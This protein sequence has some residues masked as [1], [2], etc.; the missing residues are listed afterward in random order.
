M[1]I[2]ENKVLQQ[3]TCLQ[4]QFFS[5]L[6][7]KP[8]CS[9]DLSFGLKIRSKDIAQYQKYIQPNPHT[10]LFWLCFDIDYPCVLETTFKEKVLPTPNFMISN[11]INNHCHLVYGIKEG[12]YLTDNAHINPIRY[13]HAISYSLREALLADSGYA[14]LIIKNPLHSSWDTVE[15]EQNLWS[16]PE[17]HDFLILPDKLPKKENILGLG[18]NC[19]LFHV[20]RKYA[21]KEVLTQKISGNKDSFF[22]AVLYFIEQHN[23]TFPF[24]LLYNEC[25]AIAKS[26]SSWTWKHFGNKST[27]QWAIYVKDTHTAEMQAYRGKQN[28][29]LQQSIKGKKGGLNNSSLQQSIKGLINTKEQQ[30]LKGIIGGKNNSSLQQSL[31]GQKS[32]QVRYEGSNEQLKPWE[33]LGISRSWYYTQKS[34][35]VIK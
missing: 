32:A 8:Y 15:L 24:P 25:K 6:S 7:K 5:T 21:Y 28:S 27:K 20:G 26:I 2:I 33:A 16:L 23:E 12:V 35:G 31:K 29:S 22:N 19:T 3:D 9:D 1:H 10:A 4:Q 11:P 30:S 13:A 18:R 34:L 14:G 17:L